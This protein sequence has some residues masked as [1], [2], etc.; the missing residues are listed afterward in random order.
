MSGMEN[1]NPSRPAAV[2]E[3]EAASWLRRSNFWDWSEGNQAELD[4]WLSA[5]A[6]HRVAYW[7]LKAA[8]ER[9]ERLGALRPSQARPKKSRPLRLF[10][11][12][13]AAGALIAAALVAASTLYLLQP[14]QTTYATGVG[15]HKII[16]LADGSQVE[17]NTSTVVRV[18]DGARKLWLDRGEAFFRVK[19]D[20]AHPFTVM[21]AGHRVTD[22]GTEFLVRNVSDRLEVALVEGKIQLDTPDGRMREPLLLA[23]GDVAVARQNVLYVEKK[24]ER[25]LHTALAWRQGILVFNNTTLADAAAEFNR[26]NDRKL[27]ISDASAAQLTIDGKFRSHDIE[28]FTHLAQ[29]VFSLRAT[30][31]GNRIFI[32][33]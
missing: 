23:P 18:T 19:H 11:T 16:H 13:I 6:H 4:A 24:T 15:G 9:T 5:S 26:Y 25:A 2:I 31:Q 30:K 10:S 33:R 14:A 20:A 7:R 8:L 3:A 17:L 27:V 12:R 22:L 29:T 21:V 28:D 1:A 32:S